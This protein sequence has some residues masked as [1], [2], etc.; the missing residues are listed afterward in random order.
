VPVLVPILAPVLTPFLAP[1]LAD[2]DADVDALADD[3]N[4]DCYCQGGSLDRVLQLWSTVHCHVIDKAHC[5]RLLRGAR[6]ACG[7]SAINIYLSTR[8][9]SFEL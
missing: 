1:S 6:A 3:N 7:R 4:A 9:P 5:S 2:A 8:T